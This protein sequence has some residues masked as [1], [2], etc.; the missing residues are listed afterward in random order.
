MPEVTSVPL[1][2][3][4]TGWLN[5]PLE[6]GRREKLAVTVGGVASILIGDVTTVTLPERFV[7]VQLCVVPVVGPGIET[8]A[9][10]VEDEPPDTDQWRTTLSP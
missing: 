9:R 1:H 3:I 5:Q 4:V 8:A 2:L 7:A 10:H 6:S